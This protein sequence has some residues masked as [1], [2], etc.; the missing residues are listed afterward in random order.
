MKSKVLLGVLILSLLGCS[1][2]VAA[3]KPKVVKI[4]ALPTLIEDKFFAGAGGQWF[5]TLP[6]KTAIYI[7][8]SAEQANG[9]TRG[10]VLA[11]DPLTGQK[12]W[13]FLTSGTT[14]AIATTATRDSSGNIW[15]AGNI[16]PLTS[17]PTPAPTPS[18]LLN[19]SGVVVI[20][21]APVRAGL[22]SIALW[23]VSPRGSLIASYQY[24]AGAVLEPL[25]IKSVNNSFLMSGDNFQLSVDQLGNFSKFVHASFLPVKVPATQS[26]KDGLYIWKIYIS[27]SPIAGVSGWKPTKPG[28]VIVKVGS[29][30]G[31]IYA[32][33]KVSDPLLKID[34]LTSVG[35]VVTTETLTGIKISLLK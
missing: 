30:T 16:A 5:A 10:E 27:K 22:T 13:D 25:S 32:A 21:M 23:E 9:P 4:A 12:S 11:I 33:Y 29:R 17:T 6:S 18:G 8:G 19:P 2:A 1:P 26:F 14:D 20:P 15:I 34:F 28:R 35:V 24:D 7:V 3:L 31:A